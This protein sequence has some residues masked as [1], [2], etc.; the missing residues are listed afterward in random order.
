MLETG[1]GRAANVALASLANF[2]LP[3]DISASDRYFARDIV[4]N[5]FK[6]NSDST[7]TVPTSVGT[8]AIIDAEFLDAVTQERIEL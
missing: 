4:S 2:A 7:L 3:G 1:I 6:L 5:P 8:G